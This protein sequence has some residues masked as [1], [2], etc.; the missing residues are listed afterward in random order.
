MTLEVKTKNELGSMGT[1]KDGK[2]VVGNNISVEKWNVS[3]L[4]QF[5]YTHFASPSVSKR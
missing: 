4:L 1:V 5:F 3:N 2:T